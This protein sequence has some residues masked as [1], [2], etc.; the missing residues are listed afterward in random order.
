MQIYNNARIGSN[1]D[2]NA[3]RAV[4]QHYAALP[5]F[6]TTNNLVSSLS[7]TT[8]RVVPNITVPTNPPPVREYKAIVYLFM[9]GAADSYSMLAPT[10]ACGKLHSQYISVR[11]DIAIP[12]SSLR[13]ISAINQTCN[14]FGLHPSLVNIHS[15]YNQGDAAWIA[16]VGPLVEHLNKDE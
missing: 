1:A 16:N 12:S 7:T 3:L 8:V 2:S 14:S 11:G 6:H 4:L 10:S 15:L 13:A 5:E 9:G